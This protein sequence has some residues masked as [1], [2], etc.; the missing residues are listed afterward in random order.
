MYIVGLWSLIFYRHVMDNFEGFNKAEVLPKRFQRFHRNLS[1]EKT[2]F[3][4]RIYL[5]S[6]YVVQ[7]TAPLY[8]Q[9][10]DSDRIGY[11]QDD[12]P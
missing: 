3:L 11:G 2:L 6:V 9:S 5:F 1:N 8:Y 10:A 7:P 4:L 12:H